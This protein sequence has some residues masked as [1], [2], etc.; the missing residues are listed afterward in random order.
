MPNIK[1]QIKR[2][3]TNELARQRNAA[4]K[5]KARTAIKKVEKLAAS[6]SK[7]EAT[8]AL[9]EAMS[10]L[11]K[12]AQDGIIAKNNA[13]RKKAHLQELVANIK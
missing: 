1:S 5:S 6:N 8:K 4:A 10:I 7:E 3:Q 11:D 9:A 13:D 2:D 12:I